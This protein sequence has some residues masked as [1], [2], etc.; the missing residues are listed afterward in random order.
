M[1]MTLR[2][3]ESA[4]YQAAYYNKSDV[5]KSSVDELRG[6]LYNM[7]R[8]FDMFLDKF[9]DKL[10]DTE[11]SRFDPVKKLYNS[12]YDEYSKTKQL[13]VVAENYMKKTNV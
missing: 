8:W 4:V 5:L 1:E 13:M 2:E 10:S 12:K 9:D 3:I 6:R 11:L 7:D